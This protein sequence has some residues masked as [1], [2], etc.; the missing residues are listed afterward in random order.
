MKVAA[1]RAAALF[2]EPEVS[3]YSIGRR[4]GVRDGLALSYFPSGPHAGKSPL[5]ITPNLIV[6]SIPLNQRPGL[7]VGLGYQLTV[8]PRVPTFDKN[9]IS[10][11]R[12]DF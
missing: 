10:S 7:N 11:V 6:G 8:S 2:G 3:L 9:W 4:L 1:R 12:L 5:S